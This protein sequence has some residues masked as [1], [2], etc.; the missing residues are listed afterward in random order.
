[1]MDGS[2]EPTRATASS[3]PSPATTSVVSTT[4]FRVKAVSRVQFN[5]LD[6]ERCYFLNVYVLVDEKVLLNL[7]CF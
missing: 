1:M 2:S 3:E 4:K 5:S 6:N 7:S